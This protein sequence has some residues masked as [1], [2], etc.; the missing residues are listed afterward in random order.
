MGHR[1]LSENGPRTST[2][3]VFGGGCEVRGWEGAVRRR[4]DDQTVCLSRGLTWRRDG[5]AG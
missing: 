4:M 3:G 1:H 2:S 5:F